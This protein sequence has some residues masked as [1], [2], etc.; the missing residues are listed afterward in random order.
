MAKDYYNILGVKKDAS[1]DEIKKAFRKLAHQYHPDKQ[2]GNE[3]KFKEVN[4]AYSIL[5]DDR[6][7]NEYDTYGQ[8]FN[9]AGPGGFGGGQGFGGFDFSQ[10]TQGGFGGANGQGFGDFDFG[11]IFSSVFGG[12]TRERSKR[13][14]DISIDIEISFQESVFGVN[15]KVLLTK[16]S[17]C[18]RCHGNGGEPGTEMV[19]CKTCNG[20]GRLKEVKRTILGSIATERVCEACHGKGQTPK[21]RCKECKGLGILKRAQEIEIKIPSGIEDGEM[22]R[23][24][25]AGEAVSGGSPG[26]LYVK[27]HVKRHPVFRKEGSNIVMDLNIKLS[28]ALL[29][30]ERVIPTL[31]GDIKLS[32][33]EQVGFGEILRVKGKGI[34][35]GRNRRGDLLI[36]IQIELPRKLSREAKK[37]IEGLKSEGV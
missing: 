7:R 2:G 28:E 23:L 18:E 22:V 8:T 34:S 11:D 30:G 32:I 29:G 17:T 36:K 15:R 33:P 31:D 35:D 6:K 19:S 3:T 20:K 12:A 4:E 27:I 24:S 25:G 5:S 1:K 10:F 21:E 13:G 26:D 16:A 9:G 14:R 37:L